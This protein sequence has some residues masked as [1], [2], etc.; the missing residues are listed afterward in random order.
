MSKKLYAKGYVQ[1]DEDGQ[2]KVAVASSGS[3]DR[4][5]EVLDTKGWE[6]NNFIKNPILLWSHQ[7]H[8]MPVG[9]VSNLRIEG[10]QLLFEPVFASDIDEKAA[11]IEKFYHAGILN[12]FSVGFLPKERNDNT[13]TK[14]ELLEVSVVNVPANPEALALTREFKEFLDEKGEEECTECPKENEEDNKEP[15]ILPEKTLNLVRLT[16]DSLVEL[17][18]NSKPQKGVKDIKVVPRKAKKED[19]IKKALR[20]VDKATEHA[21]HCLKEK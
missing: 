5:G 15:D 17:L 19:S 14:Q 4:D 3:L 8:E 10:D 6:L 11:K 20:L 12:A 13:Y 9:K 1:K 16:K 21:L 7:A 2:L 18:N